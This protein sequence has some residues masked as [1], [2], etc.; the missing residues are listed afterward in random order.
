MLSYPVASLRPL[1]FEDGVSSPPWRECLST[2]RSHVGSDGQGRTRYVLTIGLQTVSG[3][4]FPVQP[5]IVHFPHALEALH[6]EL[7]PTSN[8]SPQG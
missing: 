6:P 4:C 5:I 8:P 2:D 7:E 1:F 3:P